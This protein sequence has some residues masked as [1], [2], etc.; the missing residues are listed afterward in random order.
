MFTAPD[1]TEADYQAL[2]RSITDL[3]SDED[4]LAGDELVAIVHGHRGDSRQQAALDI[5]RRGFKLKIFG[6][7][8]S[9]HRSF[10]S[11]C[12][13]RGNTALALCS[14]PRPARRRRWPGSPGHHRASPAS[15]R[16]ESRR[17]AQQ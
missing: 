8:F 17:S 6:S 7:A 11:G 2:A 14:L 13:K 1:F 10:I 16:W 15:R 4:N 12:I 9:Q 3:L 5:L